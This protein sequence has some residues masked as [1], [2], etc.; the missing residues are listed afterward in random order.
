M[1]EVYRAIDTNLKR[2]V[3]IKVLPASVAADAERLARFQREAEVLGA[4]NHPNIA[5]IYGL[6]RSSATTALVMELIEGPTLADRIARGALP[7]DESLPI[8]RQIAEA[9]EAAHDRGI[10]HRDLK[11][12]NIKVRV[13]GVVKVLDFGLAKEMEPTSAISAATSMSSTITTPAMT[14]SGMILGTA[15]YMSP[16]QARGKTAD[17]RADVWAFG[18]V[19]FEML[20]GKRAFPGEDITDTIVSVVSKEPDWRKLPAAT[21]AGL[22]RLL[23]RSLKKDPRARLQAIGDARVQIEEL[24]SGAPEEA[25]APA[26]PARSPRPAWSRAVPWTLAAST[27]VFA[28]AS[29]LLWGPWRNAT[30]QPTALRFTPFAFEQGGQSNPVWAPDGKAVAFAARQKDTD[31]FQVYVR[32]LDSPLATP[33]TDLSVNAIPIAWTATGRIVFQSTE[34][35]AGLWSVSPVGGEPQPFQT[36]DA[37]IGPAAE[38]STASVSRD[39]SALAW[40]HRGDDGLVGL[41]ISSPPGSAPK[42]Y[43]PAPF[44]ARLSVSSPTVKFS[45]DGTQILLV[46]DAGAG[47]EA[48]LMPYP[49]DARNPP[50]RILQDLP[51]GRTTFSWMPN[52]RHVVVSA[53]RG[54]APPQLY[55]ADTVSGAFAVLSSGTTP[56]RSPAVSPDGSKLVFVEAPTNFDIVSMDLATASVAPLIAT[57]RNENQPAWAARESAMVYVTD[58]TG[59]A[60]IW[61]HKPGQQDRPLVSADDFPPD[62]TVSLTTPVLSPEATRVIYM[63]V[64][65]GGPGLLW[66]SAVDGGSPVRLVKSSAQRERAGS[67]S[68]DGKWFVYFHEEG[69]RSSLNKVKTTGQA[70]AEV[71]KTGIRTG[72]WLPVW[73]PAGDW[74]LYPDDRAVKL[75]SPDG[76]TTRQLSSTS[77][78]AGTF[79][80]DGRTIYGIRQRAADTLELFSMSVA[81]GTERTI[82]LFG[83]EHVPATFGGP[84]TRLSLTPD[85][86]SIT[87]STGRISSNLWLIELKGVTLP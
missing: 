12:A 3:A 74:I 28:V 29:V 73:S 55:I 46:R 80:A 1:G 35:P 79:S 52:N 5:A 44:A 85:G 26:V 39:G 87:F 15:A 41:W 7:I 10:I 38:A 6:E 47:D 67:W 75:I 27:L 42:R 22:R 63:R 21:P 83:R 81:G 13:D 32:Y 61:S 66:I 24:L 17:R 58:R 77:A 36:M 37:S 72:A 14:H 65:V 84:A 11:P 4:L 62:T 54:M 60:E 82:G 68:P 56:Q 45:P 33:I 70:E 43:E 76:R 69:D 16:E 53:S 50:R 64:E 18:A 40:L 23:A 30:P 19:L 49:A 31:P 34:P 57:T 9:V 8:A 48:W 71:L 51:L 78:V 2:S 20:T 86:K 25:S 59:V